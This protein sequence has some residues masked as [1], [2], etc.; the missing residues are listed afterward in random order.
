M[1]AGKYN[2]SIR[3]G[4][5]WQETVTFVG[6]LLTDYVVV[7]EWKNTLKVV[8]VTCSSIADP[9]TMTIAVGAE[10]TVLTPI[11]TSAQTA[12]LSAGK[13]NYLLRLTSPGGIVSTELEGTVTVVG[14]VLP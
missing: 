8:K 2:T 1:A 11:L 13:Y 9:P 10:D 12:L 7:M 5:T 6:Q 3:Q 14:S 4:D